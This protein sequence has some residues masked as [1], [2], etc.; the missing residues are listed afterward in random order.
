ME[1]SIHYK[2][3]DD[4]T[5]YRFFVRAGGLQIPTSTYSFESTGAAKGFE[6]SPSVILGDDVTS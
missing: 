6:F 2:F 3:R 4:V 5:A 1:S